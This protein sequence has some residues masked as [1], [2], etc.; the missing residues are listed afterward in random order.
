MPYVGKMMAITAQ[1]P[2]NSLRLV[3]AYDENTNAQSTTKTQS[4][5][6]S[7]MKRIWNPLRDISVVVD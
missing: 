3:S 1:I 4:K 6:D 7:V 5:V 2:P